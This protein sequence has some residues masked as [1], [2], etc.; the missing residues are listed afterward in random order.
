MWLE[1]NKEAKGS[2]LKPRVWRLG[3]ATSNTE[4]ASSSEHELTP[5]EQSVRGSEMATHGLGRASSRVSFRP[6]LLSNNKTN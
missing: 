6:W 4:K 1:K 5:V 3:F 2:L